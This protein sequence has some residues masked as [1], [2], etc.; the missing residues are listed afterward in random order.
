MP[1]LLGEVRRCFEALPDAKRS[2]GI[3]LAD[4]LMSAL[5]LFGLKYPS[6]LQFDQDRRTPSLPHNLK[7]LFGIERAPSD[8]YLRE[9]LDE[10]WPGPSFRA[11]FKR[12]FAQLQRGK[13]LEDYRVLGDY[14]LVSLDGT[15]YFRSDRVHCAQCCERHHRDGHI[16]YYHQMLGA[17]VLHPQHREVFPLLP[18][19]IVKG[20]GAR[21]NDCERNAAKR[22]LGQIRRDHPHLKAIVVEDALAANGPHIKLLKALGFRFLLGAK[23]ADHAFLFEW[24]KTDPRARTWHYTDAQGIEHRFR[25][26]NGVPLNDTHFEL[27]VNLIEYWELHPSG[28]CQ[29]FAWVTDL[30]VKPD[31]LMTLMRAGRARWKIENETFNTLKNQGYHFEHNFGH[32]YQHLATVLCCA[33]MLA[34]LIDQIQLRCCALF[35]QAL[36]H[37]ASR[38]RL[39]RQQR[40]LFDHYLI[41]DWAALYRALAQGVQPVWLEPLEPP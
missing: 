40:A 28:K 20:D 37:A 13:V 39:W 9:R 25:Y 31:R 11:A 41:P 27:E 1:A 12:L 29:H 38:V 34:F 22:L 21:K 17:V 16:S 36:A 8:T 18:E 10:V 32:G 2:R 15:G 26:L 6:L 35:N 19:P 14:Y 33:M 4:C 5:A 24:V 3:G 30:P 23:E 7:R